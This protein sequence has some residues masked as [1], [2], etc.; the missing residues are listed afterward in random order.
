MGRGRE[1]TWTRFMGASWHVFVLLANSTQSLLVPMEMPLG[2]ELLVVNSLSVLC[3]L[4][5]REDA[6]LRTAVARLRTLLSNREAPGM[7]VSRSCRPT[8][9]WSCGNQSRRAVISPR[10]GNWVRLNCVAGIK[11][12]S[13][14]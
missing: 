10:M 9:V 11:L 12:A 13:D 8:I 14:R 1:S 4:L 6:A 2:M 5:S 7:R 3:A